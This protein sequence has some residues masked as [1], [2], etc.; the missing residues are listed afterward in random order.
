M[1]V[2][3]VMEKMILYSEGNLTD[4]DHFMKVYALAKTIGELEG[5]DENTQKILEVA[6]IIHDIACPLCREK[7]GS[8][9]GKLQEKEG[10]ALARVFLKEVGAP[11]DLIERVVYL[12]EHHHTYTEVEGLDYRIL[13]EADFLVN[14]GEGNISHMCSEN[15]KKTL[16]QTSS[17][18]RLLE[19]MFPQNESRRS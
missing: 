6:A 1:T 18:L 3:Q 8:T 16:F 7:Y 19:G 12:V 15:V 4:I 17:G 11:E 10:G 13:L 5:L 9:N 14:A 2:S